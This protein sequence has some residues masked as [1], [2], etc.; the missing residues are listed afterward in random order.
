LYGTIINSNSSILKLSV[1]RISNPGLSWFSTIISWIPRISSKI[2]IWNASIHTSSGI[3][4]TWY[5]SHRTSQ[6]WI[7]LPSISHK[8]TFDKRDIGVLQ[9]T[10]SRTFSNIKIWTSWIWHSTITIGKWWTLL[11][12]L[13]NWI[14][15]N[16]GLWNPKLLTHVKIY[17]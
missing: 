2:R 17:Y 4:R 13:T 6:H 8:P 5:R 16:R 1:V 7:C 11:I 9:T 10:I 12:A 14:S 15:W 3:S